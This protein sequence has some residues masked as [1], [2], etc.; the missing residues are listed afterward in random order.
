VVSVFGQAKRGKGSKMEKF[1]GLLFLY[2][3]AS[4]ELFA[5]TIDCSLHLWYDHSGI[6]GH[7]H[8]HNFVSRYCLLS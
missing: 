7:L 8:G 3:F 1:K 2:C 4:F 5:L 6:N